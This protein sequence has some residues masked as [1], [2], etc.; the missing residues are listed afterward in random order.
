MAG[1][2]NAYRAYVDPRKLRDY[3]LD[4]QHLRGRH[5]AV[6]FES[7]LGITCEST[8]SLRTALLEAAMTQPA[9][10]VREDRYGKRYVVDFPMSGPYGEAA[11][12]SIW[13]VR[14]REDAP[15]LVTCY[16]L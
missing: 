13:I 2:P 5:K 8:D 11:I 3:C 9:Q 6:V 7:V 16:V 4:R 15:R 14:T 1:L 10:L 12:R